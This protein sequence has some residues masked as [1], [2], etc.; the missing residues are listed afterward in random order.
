MKNKSALNKK[1]NTFYIIVAG[2]SWVFVLFILLCAVFGIITSLKGISDFTYNKIGFP[3]KV[4]FSNYE[5]VF[6]GFI[7]KPALA[8]K[9]YNIIGMFEFTLIYCV[10]SILPTLV[11]TTITAYVTARFKNVFSEF[12]FVMVAILMSYSV[13]GSQASELKVLRTLSMYDSFQGIAF[14]KANFLN[15]YF[16]VLFAMFRGIPDA[17]SEAA[18][19]DGAGNF[20]IFLRIMLP[21][22]SG[23]IGTIALLMFVTMWN[24][25]QTPLIYLPSYP[26]I[27]YG[28]FSF[29]NNGP[30]KDVLGYYRNPPVQIAACMVIFIPMLVIFM[31]FQRKLIG[32]ISIGGIKE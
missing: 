25:Y 9:P 5:Y 2:V 17:Y 8:Q 32:G 20:K 15:M 27:A 14:L 10:V 12:L 21:L 29:I 24:D 3:T 19:I 31:I 23:A 30:Y 26:T 18:R 4:E 28:L 11:V 6:S 13:V 1:T 7:V 22:A 16:L